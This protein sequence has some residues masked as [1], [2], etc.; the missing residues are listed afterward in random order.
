MPKPTRVHLA[1]Q[2][3]EALDPKADELDN[4]KWDTH[5]G[6]QYKEC[7]KV[8]QYARKRN[9]IHNLKAHLMNHE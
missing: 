2:Y 7:N 5:V 1:W 8:Y 4:S 6:Y 3:F 9:T